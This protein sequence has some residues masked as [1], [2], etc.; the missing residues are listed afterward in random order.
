MTVPTMR[1]YIN[2]EW[3][4][5]AATTFGDVWNPATGEKIARVAYGTRGDVDQAVAAATAAFPEWR[6]TPPLTR[7]RYLF[8]LKEAF[9]DHFE[10]IAR[11]LTTEQGK[12]IDEA[13]GEVRRMI[14]NVEHATGVT[15]LMCGYTLEDIAKDID[16]TGHRQPLGVFAA[17]APYNFPAMVP[18]WFLPYALVCGNT[19][20]LKPSEQVP[21]TQTKVFEILDQVGFPEGV[22]NMVHGS[23]EVVNGILDHPDIAGVSFVGSSPTAKYIY[24][25]CGATGKR[26]QAL[27][28]AKNIVAVMP[29]AKLDPAM[30]SLITSFFGCTGQRCLSGSILSPV[31]GVADELIAKFTAAAQAVTLG[32]GLNEKTGMGPVVSAAH[33]QRVLGYIEKGIAEGAKL[34]LDGRSAKVKDLPN[35]FFVGP[36][37]FDDVTPDMT[38]ARE[39]IFGPVVSIVRCKNVGEVVDLIN[40]RGFANAA[41]LYTSSGAVAREFKYRVKPSMVGINIG[42]A[43]PMSFFPFGGAGQSMF[44]DIKGHG[45][46]IFQFFT[47]TKVVIE[48]WL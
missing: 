29:D 19:F 2:G 46:E 9:E 47:D 21:M 25:R 23:R 36:T 42:I 4:E 39:E 30:P 16:C 10:E 5:S 48:R 35:G 33:R 28:G 15:T 40:T 6:A 32:D 43:A 11:V 41:C 13:R 12:V 24:E 31:G 45:Q 37:I 44:G 26:V 27:G 38:I 17:I 8:R 34:I 20:V 18:W 1:N 22:V 3:V 7:A 14:E